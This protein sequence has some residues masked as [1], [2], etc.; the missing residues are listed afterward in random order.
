[1]QQDLH[2]HRYIAYNFAETHSRIGRYSHHLMPT[3]HLPPLETVMRHAIPLMLFT[4]ASACTPPSKDGGQ[5]SENTPPTAEITSPIDGSAVT[6]G[7][8]V[9]L[10]GAVDDPDGAVADLEVSWVVDGI[11]ACAE[12]PDASGLVT[13]DAS[14]GLDGGTVVLEVRDP[15]GASATAQ[16]SVLVESPRVAP[17]VERVLL[18]PDAPTTNDVLEA[19]VTATAS[20]D[21]PL[22]ITYEWFVDDDSVQEGAAAQLDGA[23]FF[24]KGQSIYVVA[25]ASDG[26]L[27]GSATSDMVTVANTPPAAPTVTVTPEVASPGEALVCNVTAPSVD[28]DADII[29]YTMTWTVDGDAH[30]GTTETGAWSGD[31]LPASETASEQTWTCL[32]TPDDG[33]DIGDPAEAFATICALGTA[34]CAAP[35]CLTILEADASAASGMWSVDPDGSGAS[36][37]Y[38]DMDA[39][40]W[41]LISV[42]GASCKGN[43]TSELT[44][45][46]ASDSCAYLSNAAVMRLS[47]TATE[48]ALRG[49]RS[50]TAF[51]SSAFSTSSAAI[52]ALQTGVDWHQTAA[53]FDNWSW[54]APGTGENLEGWPDMWHSSDRASGVHWFFSNG[55]NP[56]AGGQCRTTTCPDAVTTTWIR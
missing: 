39:G 16:R 23:E 33:E 36:E 55:V 22:T 11:E 30:T 17:A 54:P 38:C 26:T 10:Q 44:T 45:L 34:D 14:F 42:G 53:T 49:G 12:P 4:A 21:A 35:S 50:T 9:S 43:A 20:D 51:D 31:T 29:T 24:E 28:E 7:E 5:A 40:G 18:Q 8:V 19:T 25:T 52:D 32:A 27:E 37:V 3:L 46:G 1:M 13:C 6:E 2:I 15:L 56:T 41:M 47:M 48:V